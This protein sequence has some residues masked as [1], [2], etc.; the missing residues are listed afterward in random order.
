MSNKC[1]YIRNGELYGF[2]AAEYKLRCSFETSDI[3]KIRKNYVLK[4]NG[5]VHVTRN[6]A[7]GKVSA[8]PIIFD[9]VDIFVFDDKIYLLDVNND[10]L[11]ED[12][13]GTFTKFKNTFGM[14][15]PKNIIKHRCFNVH[16]NNLQ[17]LVQT[18]SRDLHLIYYRA[19][20]NKYFQS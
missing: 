4:K 6:I 14:C 1:A 19:Y 17:L 8:H 9:I 20:G 12:N 15:A 18:E 11:T 2:D 3:H 5:D 16:C 10:I 13:S 7:G